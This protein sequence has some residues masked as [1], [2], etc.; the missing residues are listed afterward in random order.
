MVW[1]LEE[2]HVSSPL[3]FL[4][5]LSFFSRRPHIFVSV[6]VPLLFLL[7][8]CRLQVRPDH[9]YRHRVPHLKCNKRTEQLTKKSVEKKADVHSKDIRRKSHTDIHFRLPWRRLFLVLSKNQER[10]CFSLPLT[11]SLG[12]YYLFDA[13]SL[14][15]LF[16]AFDWFWETLSSYSFS[17]FASLPTKDEGSLSLSSRLL[18]I[19]CQNQ[20]HSLRKCLKF[21]SPLSSCVQSHSHHHSHSLSNKISLSLPLF[22]FYRKAVSFPVL[23]SFPVSHSLLSW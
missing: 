13:P 18:F 23:F 20:T 16:I 2:R 7:Q 15:S 9:H 11:S 6:S 10:N 22:L 1:I 19:H 3:F 8:E 12:Y 4:L 17:P 21:W 14:S 5:V